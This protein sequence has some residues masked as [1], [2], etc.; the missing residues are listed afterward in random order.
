[1]QGNAGVLTSVRMLVVIGKRKGLVLHI[2]SVVSVVNV[3]SHR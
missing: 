1:M 2:S 3:L